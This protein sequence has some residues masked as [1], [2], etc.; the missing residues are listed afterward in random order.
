LKAGK[1]V[2]IKVSINCSDIQIEANG[3]EALYRNSLGLLGCL[4]TIVY[5]KR[6]EFK[7]K[8]T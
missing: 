7:D 3:P 6:G 8:L 2:V 1:E 5:L 4:Q